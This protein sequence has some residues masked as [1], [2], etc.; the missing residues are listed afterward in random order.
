MHSL[1]KGCGTG[2]RV[3]S[4]AAVA[5]GGGIVTCTLRNTFLCAVVHYD[6]CV[7]MALALAG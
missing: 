2:G 5:Q 6:V 7:D 4:F 3:H 1:S